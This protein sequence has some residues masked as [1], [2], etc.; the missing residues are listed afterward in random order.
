MFSLL[1]FVQLLPICAG[2][3]E[4]FGERFPIIPAEV[5]TQGRDIKPIKWQTACCSL[6]NYHLPSITTG[7]R[8]EIQL[9]VLQKPNKERNRS[10]QFSPLRSC[11]S[12][13]GKGILPWHDKTK[14]RSAPLWV[15]TIL[16]FLTRD[17]LFTKSLNHLNPAVVDL[18][19]HGEDS[20]V[21]VICNMM[22]Y[23]LLFSYIQ[24]KLDVL[25]TCWIMLDMFLIP[26]TRLVVS[27]GCGAACDLPLYSSD[28]C[29]AVC[30]A[31]GLL[32]S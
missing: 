3:R 4:W 5:Q 30:G 2:Y 7:A 16:L 6:T 9:T 1:L 12:T 32:R 18:R 29:Q 8:R 19:L 21:L 27:S 31:R 22:T 17:K 20:D 14:E 11:W 26:C 13:E 15:E 10:L 28:S 23:W 24:G 25:T